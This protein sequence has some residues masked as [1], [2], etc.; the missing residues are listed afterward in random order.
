MVST[1]KD[2]M[3]YIESLKIMFE[4]KEA[5]MYQTYLEIRNWPRTFNAFVVERKASLIDKKEALIRMMDKET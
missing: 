5:D 4:G 2:H 3:D 1:L